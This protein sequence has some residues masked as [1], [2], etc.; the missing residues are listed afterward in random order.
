M[1][2]GSPRSPISLRD[3]A[4]GARLDRAHSGPRTSRKPPEALNDRLVFETNAREGAVL[5]SLRVIAEQITLQFS[6]P[7]ALAS[8]TRSTTSF[9]VDIAQTR[10][11]Y[12]VLLNS[13]CIPR[14]SYA[15][16]CIVSFSIVSFP[17]GGGSHDFFLPRSRSNP[18]RSREDVARGHESSRE[19]EDDGKRFRGC[20]LGKQ[21]AD[22]PENLPCPRRTG[23]RLQ[24]LHVSSSFTLCLP[25]PSFSLYDLLYFLYFLSSQVSSPEQRPYRFFFLRCRF[26]EAPSIFPGCLRAR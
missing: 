10:F 7:I 18:R 8:C 19:T 12:G 16:V 15:Y 23:P 21:S 3:R 9:V 25:S 17:P 13:R 14:D 2:E 26:R 5:A 20:F 22:H 24:Y 6:L 11:E 4:K 1:S